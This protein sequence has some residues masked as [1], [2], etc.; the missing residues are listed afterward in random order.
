MA[1]KVSYNFDIKWSGMNLYEVYV[2][3]EISY[4]RVYI[5]HNKMTFFIYT[6]TTR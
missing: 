3:Q 1:W 5:R 4:Y 2:Y 6:V